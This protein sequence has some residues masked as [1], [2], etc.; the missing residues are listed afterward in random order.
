[1]RE[2]EDADS[3]TTATLLRHLS[4]CVMSRQE[5]RR[6]RW[7]R[8]VCRWA[9]E[10]IP[11]WSRLGHRWPISSRAGSTR[12]ECCGLLQGE[13]HFHAASDACCW[14]SWYRRVAFAAGSQGTKSMGWSGPV[15]ASGL[16]ESLASPFLGSWRPGKHRSTGGYPLLEACAAVRPGDVRRGSRVVGWV[17]RSVFTPF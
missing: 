8:Y 16:P 14:R 2:L 7:L 12:L 1:M 17:A 6:A 10:T 3:A 5:R 15:C 4:R 9:C 13:I 11:M